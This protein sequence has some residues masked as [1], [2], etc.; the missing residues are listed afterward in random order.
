MK[1]Y[2]GG[3]RVK[4]GFYWNYGAWTITTVSDEPG[5]LPGGEEHRYAKV[6]PVMLLALAPLMGAAYVMFLPLLGFALLFGTAGAKGLAVVKKAVAAARE[7]A[8]KRAD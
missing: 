7:V 6:P 4:P 8:W 5:P 2:R 1:T 3:M